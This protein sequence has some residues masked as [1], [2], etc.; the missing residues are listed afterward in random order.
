[1]INEVKKMKYI[2]QTGD[3]AEKNSKNDDINI[4]FSSSDFREEL[5]QN[6]ISMFKSTNY[7]SSNSVEEKEEKNVY[8]NKKDEN[9]NN[10]CINFIEKPQLNKINEELLLNEKIIYNNINN[11]I[12]NNI[13]Y[14]IINNNN[15][16]NAN[17]NY[18]NHINLTNEI[19]NNIL[20]NAVNSNGGIYIDAHNMN[21]ENKNFSYRENENDFVKINLNPY[22]DLFNNN[23]GNQ[24]REENIMMNNIFLNEYEKKKVLDEF[25]YKF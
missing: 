25:M 14:S 18:I 10:N 8:K 20:L 23:L 7:E 4:T 16:I 15:N 11:N 17:I 3:D 22:I 9:D 24:N 13:N 5:K 19:Y 12:V 6:N 2:K 21:F 1:M